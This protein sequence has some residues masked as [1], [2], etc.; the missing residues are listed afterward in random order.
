M[1]TED[2]PGSESTAIP[3]WRHSLTSLYPGSEIKGVPASETSANFSHDFI[4][5]ISK[6]KFFDSLKSFNTIRGLLIW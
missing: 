2:G 4:R 1:I 3:W 6:A 5:E